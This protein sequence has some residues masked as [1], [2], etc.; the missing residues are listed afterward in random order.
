LGE[1]LPFWDRTIDLIVLTQPQADHLTGLLEVLDKYDVGFII[2][3]GIEYSSEIYRRWVKL[4]EDKGIKHQITHTDQKINL[5]G[6]LEIDVLNPPKSL[7]QGT[8][9]DINNNSL[10]LRLNYDEV[11]FL[12]A[13]DIGLDAERILI[14]QRANLKSTALKVAHHGSKTSTSSGFLSVVDP[15]VASISAGSSNK[16]GLPNTEVTS[17]LIEQLGEDR[18]YVT[19]Q[20]R[21]I[22]FI[23]DG[24][25]LW[26]KSSW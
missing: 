9:D 26:V 13:A 16:L 12:F 10:V 5:G 23:T 21:T 1:K 19:A 17:R 18:V 25:R 6:G 15:E 14:A 7:L 11:S 4:V 2:E 20:D 3:P 22:E 24:K 8:P